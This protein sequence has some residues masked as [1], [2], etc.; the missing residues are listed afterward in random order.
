M[1]GKG[2]IVN[3]PGIPAIVYT[4]DRFASIK[5]EYVNSFRYCN[6]VVEREGG[7]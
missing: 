7:R 6:F 3:F 2:F 5:G 1:A 4:V